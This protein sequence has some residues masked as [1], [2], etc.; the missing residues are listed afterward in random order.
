MC[1]GQRFQDFIQ[2]QEGKSHGFQRPRCFEV[3]LRPKSA[4]SSFRALQAVHRNVALPS[5][6]VSPEMPSIGKKGIFAFPGSFASYQGE[7]LGSQPPEPWLSHIRSSKTFVTAQG[8]Q[9]ASHHTMM[10]ALYQRHTHHQGFDRV[11]R[12]PYHARAL[13]R[14]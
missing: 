10:A 8:E 12:R 9:A 14:A 5:D 13:L 2:L 3:C 6:P 1:I 4:I 7:K 11:A